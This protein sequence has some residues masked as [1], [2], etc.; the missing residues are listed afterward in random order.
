[1]IPSH[2]KSQLFFH[3][4][5]TFLHM[6]GYLFLDFHPTKSVY[7]RRARTSKINLAHLSGQVTENKDG[8]KREPCGIK[9][10]INGRVEEPLA[11]ERGGVV[12]TLGETVRGDVVLLVDGSRARRIR[13]V[14]LDVLGQEPE[15]CGPYTSKTPTPAPLAIP[16]L[17]R[18]HLDKR[19]RR[20][21]S[22]SH[23]VFGDGQVRG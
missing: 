5:K 16:V 13:Q 19:F 20:W 17:A 12:G 7:A 11:R 3:R 2:H 21:V 18:V 4:R 10:L 15:V 6:T 14:R 1:M 23:G 8:R 9:S 22:A